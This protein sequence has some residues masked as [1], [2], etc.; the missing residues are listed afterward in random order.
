MFLDHAIKYNFFVI[1]YVEGR[2]LLLAIDTESIIF[3]SKRA[4]PFKRVRLQAAICTSLLSLTVST[5]S[6]A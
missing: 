2:D 3:N 1:Q 4:E 5:N 6:T